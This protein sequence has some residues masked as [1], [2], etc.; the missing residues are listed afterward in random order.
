MWGLWW[1]KRHW[2]RFSPTT[3][4]SLANHHSTNFSIIIITRSWHNRRIGGRSAKWTQL[5]S[6]PHYSNLSM[7]LQS[8]VGPWPLFSVSKSYTQSVGLFG[9]GI[10]Q[11]LG[12]YLHTEQHEQIRTHDPR[13]RASEGS[14]F[15]RPRGHLD[16]LMPS[17]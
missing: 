9:Q 11:S 8:F 5:D 16:R 2:D 12:R 6:T 7:A 17:L 1:T 10:N 3:S 13:V 4:V 14:S 15:L